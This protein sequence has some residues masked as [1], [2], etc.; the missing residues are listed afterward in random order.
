M[1]DYMNDCYGNG[2]CNKYGKCECDAGFFG[3]DCSATVTDLTSATSLKDS[4]TVSA[5]RWFYY[6]VPAGEVDWSV[7]V[8]SDRALSVYVRKGSVDLPD[9]VTYDSYIKDDT[10]ITFS[11]QMMNL[12]SGAMI[13]VHI[14]GEPEDSTS[15]TIK[16]TEL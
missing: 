4:Q 10:S 12:S 7:N 8:V 3:A 11:S 2:S 9:T 6:E 15:F 13:A 16:L 14:H 5:S 1:C